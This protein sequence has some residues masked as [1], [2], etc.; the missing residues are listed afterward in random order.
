MAEFRHSHGSEIY[1]LRACY[2]DDAEDL[3]AIGGAHSVEVLLITSHSCKTIAC[4]HLGTR[5]TSLTWSSRSSS[6]SF[7]DDWSIELAAAGADHR[8][9][10][11]SKSFDDEEDVF[12]FGGGLTGHHGKINDMTFCGG[13]SED[14]FRYIATVSD[15]KMLM[16]WNLNPPATAISPRL[17]MTEGSSSTSSRPQPTAYAITF[18]HPLATVSSHPTTNKELLVSD[19]H[20]SIFLT[21]WQADPDAN[22]QDSW[23]NSSVIELVEPRALSSSMYGFTT[24]WSGSVAWRRDKAEIVGAA[25]G[26]RFAIW[27]LTDLR[28]GKPYVMGTTFPEGGHQFR[29]CPTLSDYFAVSCNSPTKGAVIHLHNMSYIHAQPVVFNVGP[30]PLFVRTFDFMASRGVVPRIAAAVG[31]DVIVFSI[32]V[33]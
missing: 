6:P 1:A 13:Q 2:G 4:F 10:L 21:D 19:C 28:G 12:V 27:D 7:A 26:S 24:R 9:Y 18:L 29:W 5:V 23:R 32:G 17:S 15:D 14:S 20:G 33:D 11:L 31:R 3:V 25:F 30:R 16:I 8:L 22:E